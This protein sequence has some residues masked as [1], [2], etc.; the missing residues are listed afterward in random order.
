MM[1]VTIIARFGGLR[2][3]EG[4]MAGTIVTRTAAMC[5]YHVIV[6]STDVQYP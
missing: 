3:E 6:C 2:G 5:C 1:V 4:Q